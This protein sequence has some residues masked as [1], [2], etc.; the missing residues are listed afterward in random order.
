MAKTEELIEKIKKLP[1][2]RQEQVER[3]IKFLLDEAK[4]KQA[5]EKEKEIQTNKK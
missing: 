3:Y 5:S 1:L 4:R 2:D